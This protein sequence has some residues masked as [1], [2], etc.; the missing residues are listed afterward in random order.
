MPLDKLQLFWM[1][2]RAD[3]KLSAILDYLLSAYQLLL[4]I[5]SPFLETWPGD[6]QK[7]SGSSYIRFLVAHQQRMVYSVTKGMGI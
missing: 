4:V 1:R 3:S 6:V 5:Y 7:N 2:I